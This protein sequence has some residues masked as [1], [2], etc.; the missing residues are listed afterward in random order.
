M[1]LMARLLRSGMEGKRLRR[2]QVEHTVQSLIGM[3]VYHFAS[4]EFGDN[5]L[6]ESVFAPEQVQNRKDH[7]L[8]VFRQLLRVDA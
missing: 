4:G 6:G 7:V 5:L 3:V 8:H 2:V 1:N